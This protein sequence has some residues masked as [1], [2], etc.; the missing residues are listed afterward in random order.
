MPPSIN[1]AIF[2]ALEG[3]DGSGKSTQTA[4]LAQRMVEVGLQVYRTFEPTDNPIGSMIRRIFSHQMEADQRTIAGLFVADRLHHLLCPDTGILRYLSDGVSVI[5]DRYYFSSYAYHGVH[6]DMDWVIQSNAMSASLLRPHVNIFIDVPPEVS[7]ERMSASR[8]SMEMYE[9]LDNLKKVRNKYFE[10]F[11]R[12]GNA[13]RVVILNGED[14][15]KRI[16][17]SI[18]E[19]VKPF[20][21]DSL[22]IG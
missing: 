2:V 9:T 15:P 8:E 12:I 22:L 13:E 6:T 17:E 11:E 18:W 10:A 19:T 21:P 1:P 4:L 7:M 16:S 3:I 5:T 14:D 20:L